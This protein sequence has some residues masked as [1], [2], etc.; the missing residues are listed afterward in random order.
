MVLTRA[1]KSASTTKEPSKSV[2]ESKEPSKTKEPRKPVSKIK[3]PRKSVSRTKERDKLEPKSF[4]DFPP[5]IR[6]K[7]YRFLFDGQEIAIRPLD[8]TTTWRRNGNLIVRNWISRDQAFGLNILFASK[9]T[10]AEAKPMLLALATFDIS[11]PHTFLGAGRRPQVQQGFSFVDWQSTHSVTIRETTLVRDL[12]YMMPSLRA[13]CYHGPMV[14]LGSETLDQ[15][16]VQCTQSP[17]TFLVRFLNFWKNNFWQYW[18]AD[19]KLRATRSNLQARFVLR[20][21]TNFHG[22]NAV[23]FHATASVSTH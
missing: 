1:R 11:A 8:T 3:E 18:L 2:S 12:V 20:H 9:G 16:K 21:K 6:N 7:I 4:S 13:I 14:Y 23:S 17:A 10:L 15:F 5:E 22:K 19:L